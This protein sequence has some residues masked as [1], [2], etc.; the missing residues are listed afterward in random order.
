MKL[1]TIKGYKLTVNQRKP[2]FNE[3]SCFAN[4]CHFWS[5]LTDKGTYI[6]LNIGT[7]DFFDILYEVRDQ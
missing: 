4:F 2:C 3:N 7:L 1:D 5:F 6:F